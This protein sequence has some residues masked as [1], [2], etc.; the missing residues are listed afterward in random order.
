MNSILSRETRSGRR[1]LASV[2]AAGAAV[3]A[4]SLAGA[5]PASAQVVYL[6]PPAA[7]FENAPPPRAGYVWQPGYWGWEHGRYV[8]VRGEWIGVRD[9]APMAP[10]PPVA[11]VMRLSADALFPFDRADVGDILPGGRAQIRTIAEKLRA[12]PIGRIE[13]RGYTDRLGSSTYNLGLSQRRAEAIKALLVEQGI[14]PERIDARGLGEQDSIT[15][16]TDNQPRDQLVRCLQ[17]DRRVDIVTFSRI[18]GRGGPPI[19]AQAMVGP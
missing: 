4:G 17:P 8:W 19:A 16:C 3:I 14:A 18:A 6:A 11:N 5:L 13:V 12:I 7:H 15:Q 9:S 10:P 1:R 2:L